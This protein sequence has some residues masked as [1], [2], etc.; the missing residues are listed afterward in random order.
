MTEK[1]EFHKYKESFDF[2]KN[3]DHV[4]LDF[5]MLAVPRSTCRH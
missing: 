5:P 1:S 3:V 2:F 4:I